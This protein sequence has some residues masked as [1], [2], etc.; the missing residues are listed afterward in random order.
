MLRLFFPTLFEWFDTLFEWFDTLPK[1]ERNS[2]TDFGDLADLPQWLLCTKLPGHSSGVSIAAGVAFP[3]GSDIDFN[4]QTK[5]SG[6]CE[7]ILIL[8]KY[9]V[10][11]FILSQANVH[12][13]TH[14]PIPTELLNKWQKRVGKKGAKSR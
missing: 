6:F 7:N 11:L 2:N 4:M 5:C 1:V 3:T 14:T 9:F 10:T 12:S 8:S 13:G